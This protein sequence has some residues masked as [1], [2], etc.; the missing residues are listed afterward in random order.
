MGYFSNADEI[1]NKLLQTNN[2]FNKNINFNNN[3][4]NL[5]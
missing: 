2:Q 1:K 5:K 3:Y 4:N